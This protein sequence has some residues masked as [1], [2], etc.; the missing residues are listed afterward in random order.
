MLE[1]R[2]GPCLKGREMLSI[3]EWVETASYPGPTSRFILMCSD[4]QD[5]VDYRWEN[6]YIIL[7]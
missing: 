2:L 6:D 3:V 5:K 4:E 7:I 1:T